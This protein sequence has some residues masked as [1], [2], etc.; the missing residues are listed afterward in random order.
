MLFTIVF[1]RAVRAEIRR[2]IA[3]IPATAAAAAAAAAD[4]A[5]QMLELFLLIAEGFPPDDVSNSNHRS[6]FVLLFLVLL[7]EASS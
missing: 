1:H 6:Y 3:L 7:P 2:E 4:R 5:G